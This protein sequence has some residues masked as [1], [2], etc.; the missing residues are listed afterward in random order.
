MKSRDRSTGIKSKNNWRN[1][2]LSREATEK[3]VKKGQN[4]MG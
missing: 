2:E 1:S 3:T 4:M